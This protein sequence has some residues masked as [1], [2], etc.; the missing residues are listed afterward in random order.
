MNSSERFAF[1]CEE[2]DY[3]GAVTLWREGDVDMSY[4]DCIAFQHAVWCSKIARW[5]ADTSREEC[6]DTFYVHDGCCSLIVSPRPLQSLEGLRMESQFE[7][8]H[9]YCIRRVSMVRGDI[10]HQLDCS[11]SLE[12][13]GGHLE[14]MQKLGRDKKS[15]RSGMDVF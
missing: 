6:L 2:E 14:K 11:L 15:A 12:T 4:N 13:V 3:D 10:V 1:L 8:Y 7:G 9:I 5:M